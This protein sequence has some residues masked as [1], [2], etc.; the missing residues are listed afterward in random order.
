MSTI[1]KGSSVLTLINVFTV[2]P[3]KQPELVALLIEATELTMKHLPGFVSANIHRSLDGK[4]VVNYAQWENKA[5][6]EAMQK[7]PEAAP[8]MKAAAALAQFE[9]ILCEVSDAVSVG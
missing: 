9:P 1:E 4:K 3:D 2:E 7:N 8:H 5:A 6:F